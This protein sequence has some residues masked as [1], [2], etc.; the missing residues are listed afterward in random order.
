MKRTEL[1]LLLTLVFTLSVMNARADITNTKHNLSTSGLGNIKA[2]SE[3]RICVFCHTPHNSSPNG[4]LWNRDMPGFNY[5]P[6][7]SSTAQALPG[8]PTGASLLC[9]SCHDGTIALGKTLNGQI[10]MQGGVT[11]IPLGATNLSQDLR[12]DHP[13]SFDYTSA[14]ATR[15]GELVDPGTL[16]GV[17][18]LDRSGQLQCT[19]CHDPHKNDFGKFLVMS[20]TRGALCVTCHSKNQWN[21]ASHNLSNASWDGTSTDPW[22]FTEWTTVTNNACQNCHQPHSAGSGERLLN[23]AD[24]EANCTSCHNGH[25]AQKDVAAEFNKFSRHP[26]MNTT[27]VHDAAEP[28]VINA[29]HV[30]CFDC[31]N[32]HA[33]RSTGGAVPGPLTDVRGVSTSGN[34]VD[35]LN[36][37]FELCFRCHG[38]STNKPAALTTRQHSQTNVRME[39][40]TANPSYHPVTGPGRNS[41]VPS[42]ISAL[43]T[44]SEIKCTDCHNNNN[45]P[46][47][48]GNGPNGPHGS[49]FSPLLERRYVTSDP[50]SFSTGDYALCFKCHS[51]ASITSN[52]SGFPHGLHTGAGGGGHMGGRVNAPCNTCHDPHGISNTQGNVTNNSKL[53]NFNTS[54]VSPNSSGLLYYETLG[55]YQGR[56]YLSCHGM[57]HNPC[58]YGTGGGGMGGMN[59]MGGG[60]QGGRM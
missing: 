52:Q 32:P 21:Q 1:I 59:C 54:V 3:S 8:Q 10:A 5:Q 19:S 22:P 55:T 9:L 39:F 37:E 44:S 13:I 25:V 48:N 60:G 56:C 11:T 50:N 41:N 45:G 47:A 15:N 53:I 33:A 51:E 31:H 58:T 14:L 29:R 43:S 30:E 46:N 24:E 34:E 20:N 40:N 18:K 7:T 26:I 28:A 35:P 12:D 27:G 42:L 23:Y 4:P 57:N 2:S 38:D 6:Y 16:S 36:N 17:V 49:D